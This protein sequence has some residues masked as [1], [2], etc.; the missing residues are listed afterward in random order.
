M[1]GVAMYIA[2]AIATAELKAANKV[3]NPDM[4]FEIIK[5]PEPAQEDRSLT[6]FLWGLFFGSFL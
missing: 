2:S 6:G 5:T 1:I 4:D 3:I